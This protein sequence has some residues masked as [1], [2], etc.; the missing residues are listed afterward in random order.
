VVFARDLSEVILN[1][2]YKVLYLLAAC[3][4]YEMTSV[5]LSIRAKVK[6]GE[7]PAPTG[8]QAFAAYAIASAKGLI[9]EMEN[10]A[11]QTLDLPMTFES[12]G[13]GLRLFEG[14]ALRD[15]A[16]FRKRCRDNLVT[17]LDSFEVPPNRTRPRWLD[18]VFLRVQH[19]LKHRMFSCSLDIRSRIRREYDPTRQRH[20]A[21]NFCFG[22]HSGNRDGSTFCAEIENKL[23]Q[24]QNKVTYARYFSSITRLT[25]RR[26]AVIAGP[27]LA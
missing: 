12:L 13:G 22:M 16:G 4:K 27:N 1:S 24:A 17:C 19:D 25:S 6:C 15:L 11:R 10:A 14:R 3:Q 18:H 20:S 7:F 26:Y 8:H 9:P 23:A 21:C 2:Y 5:Q